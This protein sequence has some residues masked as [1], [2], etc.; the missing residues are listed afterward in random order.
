MQTQRKRH[1]RR[2][3][4]SQSTDAIR[5]HRTQARERTRQ[6]WTRRGQMARQEQ[7][8]ACVRT[9]TEEDSRA[10][11]QD[12]IGARHNRTQQGC[13]VCVSGQRPP[14]LGREGAGADVEEGRVALRRNLRPPLR[15][16]ITPP[17]HSTLD[18]RHS[19]LDT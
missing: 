19:T 7:R 9:Q 17:Q 14:V 6:V 11:H 18:T 4:G 8:A 10:K 2:S 15:Q 12:T 5:P 16:S 1:R 13:C 3:S